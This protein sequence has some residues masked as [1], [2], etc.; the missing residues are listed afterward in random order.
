MLQFQV[1]EK[2]VY[3]AQGVAEI[4]GIEKKEIAGKIHHFFCLRILDSDMKILVPV[5]KAEQVGLR[6]LADQEQV[7]EVYRILRSTEVHLD[8][9]TWNRRYRG[10]M[11]KIKTGSLFDVAEVYRD[12][13]R[14]KTAKP[15]SFGE[16]RMLDTAR[17]LM[18]KELSIVREVSSQSI[19]D[20][21]E[22]LFAN[23]KASS[24]AA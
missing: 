3:P 18:V 6:R 11:E 14:L 9:Q 13:C 20:E 22:T 17:T 5:D 12:L 23:G 10:F 16:R 15:L 21:L 8:K 24:H 2:A 1:G 4:T 19:E 7:E